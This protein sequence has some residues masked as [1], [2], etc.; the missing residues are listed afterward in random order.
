MKTESRMARFVAGMASEVSADATEDIVAARHDI[1]DDTL[2]EA[3][4]AGARTAGDIANGLGL[5]GGRGTRVRVGRRLAK[6]VCDRR[7]AATRT[8]RGT[9][10]SVMRASTKGPRTRAKASHRR[11][12]PTHGAPA[13]RFVDGPSESVTT[14]ASSVLAHWLRRIADAISLVADYTER[15]MSC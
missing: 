7:L 13:R 10:Y 11:P 9:E 1:D 3:V 6:L 12:R 4:E 14:R 2:V 5:N 15:R 8:R